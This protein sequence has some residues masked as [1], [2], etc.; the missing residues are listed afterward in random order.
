MKKNI[1]YLIIVLILILSINRGITQTELYYFESFETWEISTPNGWISS[2]DI[3]LKNNS[4]VKYSGTTS[5]QI[6]AITGISD[7]Y[8]HMREYLNVSSL[9]SY[10]ANIHVIDTSDNF[11]LQLKVIIYDIE[12]NYLQAKN[13]P[14]SKNDQT[15]QNLSVEFNV[16]E[17]GKYMKMHIDVPVSYK[18]GMDGLLIFDDLTVE[19]IPFAHTDNKTSEIIFFGSVGIL[20]LITIYL[21]IKKLKKN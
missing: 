16:P 15:W 17:N 11:S 6:V 19:E 13:T 9:H 4:D 12:E 3:A 5:V 2:I 14:I 21:V 20:I 7:T 1:Y 10:K 8:V 18:Y